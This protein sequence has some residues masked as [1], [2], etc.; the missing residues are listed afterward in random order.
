MAAVDHLE[1]EARFPRAW[2]ALIIIGAVLAV[3]HAAAAW[4]SDSG[5]DPAYQVMAWGALAAMVAGIRL[6]R[7]TIVRPWYVMAGGVAL[8][9]L[10]DLL[11]ARRGLLLHG[12]RDP[13][14]GD[15]AHL[16]GYVLLA[17]GLL[18]ASAYGRAK[19]G[20][21]PAFALHLLYWHLPA[22]MTGLKRTPPSYLRELAG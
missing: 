5:L 13:S 14:A 15:V 4:G 2:L 9:V 18:L 3:A 1:G 20:K 19:A 21:H 6:N 16:L 12:D 8:L 22:F 17:V 10:G 11:G 7:P